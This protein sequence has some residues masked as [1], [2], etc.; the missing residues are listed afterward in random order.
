LLRQHRITTGLT[1]E[2]LA[3]RAGLSLY[4]ILKLETGATHPYGNTAQRL[5]SALDL[6]ADAA[7]QFQAAVA[8]SWQ[9]PA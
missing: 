8:P 9:C 2:A 3:E 7:E 1:Q 4:G 6:R 5:A